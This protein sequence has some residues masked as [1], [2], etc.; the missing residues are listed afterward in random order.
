M[1][2]VSNGGAATLHVGDG[3][4]DR[5]WAGLVS[6]ESHRRLNPRLFLLTGF[7]ATEAAALSKRNRVAFTGALFMWLDVTPEQPAAAVPT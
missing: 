4:G 1:Y 5:E 3:A 6:P 7:G 2:T